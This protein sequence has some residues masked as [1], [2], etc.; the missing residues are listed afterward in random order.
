MILNKGC[1]KYHHYIPS[2]NLCKPITVLVWS[3]LILNST[4]LTAFRLPRSYFEVPYLISLCWTEHSLPWSLLWNMTAFLQSLEVRSIH[5]WA[6]EL[7]TERHTEMS[8]SSPL[9]GGSLSLG[10]LQHRT[11]AAPA[12]S[13]ETCACS[14]ASTVRNKWNMP[15]V[16]AHG[17]ASKKLKGRRSFWGQ[18]VLGQHPGWAAGGL[19]LLRARRGGTQA[20][21]VIWK[22]QV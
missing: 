11:R 9:H 10:S 3:N 15:A 6:Q 18:G 17:P 16:Y 12:P 1:F 7:D 4:D 8:L 20:A 13:P 21:V 19:H 22:A 5:L 14:N 2:S